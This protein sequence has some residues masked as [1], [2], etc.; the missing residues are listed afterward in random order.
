MLPN[1]LDIWQFSQ[2][3][4][5]PTRTQ[6]GPYTSQPHIFHGTFHEFINASQKINCVSLDPVYLNATID[7]KKN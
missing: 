2:V 6:K 1:F 5:I 4:T 3:L 7:L